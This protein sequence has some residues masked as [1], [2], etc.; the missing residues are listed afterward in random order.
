MN[1][2]ELFI[3][4]S[5]HHDSKSSL[6]ERRIRV[7]INDVHWIMQDQFKIGD[8]WYP[9]KDDYDIVEFPIE[10]LSEVIQQLQRLEKLVV[11]K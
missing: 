5:S 3:P 11:L 1:N 4:Y 9:H 7:S 8:K 6:R 2:I 10:T